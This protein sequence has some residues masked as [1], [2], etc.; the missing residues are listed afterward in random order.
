MGYFSDRVL[1][2]SFCQPPTEP[3]LSKQQFALRWY[4]ALLFHLVKY[5]LLWTMFGVVPFWLGV[6]WNGSNFFWLQL[7]PWMVCGWLMN[8]KF[9]DHIE[10][11]HM[12]TL[13]EAAAWRARNLFLWVW[14]Y[15]KLAAIF[16]TM[17][18]L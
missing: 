17:A 6:P 11:H 2:P 7:V 12:V 8:A 16:W 18:V 10:F 9:A 13:N 1:N 3:G 15:G 5:G 14:N 4:Q